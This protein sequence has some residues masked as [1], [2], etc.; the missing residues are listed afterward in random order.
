MARQSW[1]A[2]FMS[3]L[4][5]GIMHLSYAQPNT[6]GQPPQTSSAQTV[7]KNVS[8][9]IFTLFGVQV[10]GEKGVALGSA[11]AITNHLLATN[12][13]VALAGNVLFVR[14]NN[15]NKLGSVVYHY[16]NDDF[17]IVEVIDANLHQ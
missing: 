2:A 7:Y 11:I 1:A 17:C 10:E 13:H 15:E 4:I 9:S 6:S 16:D 5:I 8:N 3:Y 12:C 14:I